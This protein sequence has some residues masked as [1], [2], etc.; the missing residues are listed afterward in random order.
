MREAY[1]FS[2]RFEDAIRA[3]LGRENGPAA[4]QDRM[5]LAAAYGHLGDAANASARKAP[6]VESSTSNPPKSRTHP[7]RVILVPSLRP[8]RTQ[9]AIAPAPIKAH[10]PPAARWRRRG[11]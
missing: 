7:R 1:F 6:G 5:L 4:I 11:P 8:T 3:M 9:D 10:P 2:G